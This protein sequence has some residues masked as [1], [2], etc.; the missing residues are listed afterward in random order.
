M[1]TTVWNKELLYIGG[2][3]SRAVYELE[4]S[5]IHAAWASAAAGTTDPQP[6]QKLQIRL[7]ERFLHTLNFFA[8]HHSTPLSQ[9]GE[10][11]EASFYDCSATPLRLLSSVGVR[12]A[13][14]IKQYDPDIA[15]FLKDMP[16]LPESVLQE[17][18]RTITMLQNQGMIA[19][20]TIPDVLRSLQQHQ[21]NKEELVSCLGWWIG[22]EEDTSAVDVTQLL[23]ATFF[24]NVSG[25]IV[26]L[27][28]VQFFVDPRTLGG[29]IPQDSPLPTSLLPQEVTKQFS[30]LQLS[31]FGWKEFT[32]V[33]WLRYISHPDL[34]AN[35]FTHDFTISTGWA[36]RVLGVLSRVFPTCS[37][38]ARRAAKEIL[39]SKTCI[40]TT[41]GLY[42]PQVAY[43]PG[44]STGL[45]H[46]L[47]LPI[48]QFPDGLKITGDIESLLSF[49]GV[50][51]HID[52]Q[53]ILER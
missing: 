46:D 52:P 29:Y 11:L 50:R 27:T 4:L 26:P 35:D 17:C 21:L 30:P 49:I 41:C 38:D 5:N 44:T 47:E 45:F 48:V 40:P 39:A 10:F 6:P 13:S 43:L 9:V 18:E 16:M 37:N 42:T 3:L 19:S 24:R 31:S 22:L 32:V 2:F 33:D 53:L 25:G 20:V 51:K 14:S 12:E 8:F 36:A 28:S 7:Q 1:I 34:M 23:G 15:K